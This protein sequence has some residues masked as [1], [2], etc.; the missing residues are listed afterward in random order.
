MT[1]SFNIQIARD[2]QS[3]E[4]VPL[5]PFLGKNFGTSISPW[6]ISLTA[7]EPFRVSQ[8]IQDPVPLQYLRETLPSNY[9]VSLQVSIRGCGKFLLK[10]SWF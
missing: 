5:G 9:D 7:M 4:Y 6:I 3:W 10:Y 2:I 1:K 8:C